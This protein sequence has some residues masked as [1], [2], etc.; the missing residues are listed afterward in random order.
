MLCDWSEPSY[1]YITGSGIFQVGLQLTDM[2]ITEGTAEY[3]GNTIFC[4]TSSGVY[5]IDEDSKEY[6]VYYTR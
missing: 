3:G 6:A 2:F 1:S 4:T 5:V